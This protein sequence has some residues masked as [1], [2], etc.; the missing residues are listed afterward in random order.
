ARVRHQPDAD[1]QVRTAA[2]AAGVPADRRGGAMATRTTRGVLAR[3]ARGGGAAGSGDAECVVFR[4]QE[5][6]VSKECGMSQGFR[7]LEVWKKSMELTEMV[8]RVSSRFPSH[9]RF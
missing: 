7:G 9:E 5:S 1:G 8:Y 2:P 6:D 3:A 4:R